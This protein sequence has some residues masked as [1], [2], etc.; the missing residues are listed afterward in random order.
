[1]MIQMD[2]IEIQIFQNEQQRNELKPYIK[3]VIIKERYMN[4]L[5]ECS[6]LFVELE[7]LHINE[8]FYE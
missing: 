2:F 4:L 5:H 8:H 7:K 6:Q 3:N 1:M